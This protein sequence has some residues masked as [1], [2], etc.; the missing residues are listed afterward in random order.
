MKG[1][2]PAF[3]WPLTAAAAA[4]AFAAAPLGFAPFV[5]ARGGASGRGSPRRRAW[6][7]AFAFLRV[8]VLGATSSRN[9][10]LSRCEI[11][12]AFGG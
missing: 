11:A 10:R 3:G 8:T 9:S 4:A 2:V 7:M 6:L 5:A 12:L 1:L